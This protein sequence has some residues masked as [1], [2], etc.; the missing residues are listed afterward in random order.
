MQKVGFPGVGFFAKK[1][2]NPSESGRL[3]RTLKISYIKAAIFRIINCSLSCNFISTLPEKVKYDS[4]KGFNEL[5]W[6]RDNRS[7]IENLRKQE[8]LKSGCL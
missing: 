7:N 6:G 4:L 8:I 5:R 1:S 3:N 2:S